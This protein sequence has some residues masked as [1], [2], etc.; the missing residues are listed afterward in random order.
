[1]EYHFKI[2]LIKN[3]LFKYS[4]EGWIIIKGA[5][6]VIKEL[7]KAKKTYSRRTGRNVGST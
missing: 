1:M 6:R 2:K 3:M 7:R 5:G 4:S